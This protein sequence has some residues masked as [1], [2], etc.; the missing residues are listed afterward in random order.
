MT[1]SIRAHTKIMRAPCSLQFP[2]HYYTMERGQLSL[3]STT[4]ELLGRNISGSALG[5][6]DYGR[7]GSAALTTRHTSIHK[8]WR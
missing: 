3:V 5:N 8:T 2:V 1:S 6:R 7:R 4:E